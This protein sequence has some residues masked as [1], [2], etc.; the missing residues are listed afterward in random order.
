MLQEEKYSIFDG[1][2]MELAN[3]DRRDGKIHDV[4]SFIRKLKDINQYLKNHVT[5][6]NLLFFRGHADRTWEALPSIYRNNNADNERVLFNEIISSCPHDFERLE[7]TFQKLVKLQHYGLPTRLLDITA[8]PL[9]ALFF[10]C[11]SQNDKE[12]E[13]IVYQFSQDEILYPDEPIVSILSNLSQMGKNFNLNK[14][15]KNLE[16]YKQALTYKVQNEITW[17]EDFFKNDELNKVICVKPKLENS[18][19]VRQD[20]AFLLFGMD[21]VKTQSAKIPNTNLFSVGKRRIIVAADAKQRIL[22]ELDIIGIN[23]AKLFPEL[24]KVAEFMLGRFN[25]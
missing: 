20:G 24:D 15:D 23:Y 11:I 14:D 22:D 5:E 17:H 21:E 4:P 12:G 25:K 7:S 1:L 8:N 10:A 3:S 9:V 2:R 13:V 6:R 18:R 19:I 16:R